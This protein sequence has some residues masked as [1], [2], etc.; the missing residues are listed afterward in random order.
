MAFN[1]ATSPSTGLRFSS[2]QGLSLTMGIVHPHAT[3]DTYANIEQLRGQLEE[4]GILH[5]ELIP[6][7]S[8]YLVHARTS[9]DGA[10]YG[11]VVAI[12]DAWT[13][14][15]HDWQH[16]RELQSFISRIRGYVSFATA[17]GTKG[18]G[19]QTSLRILSSTG[20]RSRVI[21]SD[22]GWSTRPKPGTR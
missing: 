17:G 6:D 21:S 13:R 20:P 12:V 22:C 1:R 11:Q 15:V 3:G 7:G 14:R 19:L 9:V 10:S 2:M 4:I 8:S 5:E 18:L 16:C